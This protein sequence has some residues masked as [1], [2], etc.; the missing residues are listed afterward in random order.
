MASQDLKLER[1]RLKHARELSRDQALVQIV[2]A[3]ID[4]PFTWIVGGVIALEYAER[5]KWTGN[6]ITTTA[7]T[8][9]IAAAGARA[10][11]P[12]IPELTE[13]AAKIIDALVPG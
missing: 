4:S 5:R 1:L 8:G 7:E 11:G 6:I 12:V 13:G 10:I 2:R 3:V 9:L